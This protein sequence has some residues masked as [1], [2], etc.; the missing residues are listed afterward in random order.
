MSM[1]LDDLARELM[2]A[3]RAKRLAAH[4]K[5]WTPSMTPVTDLGYECIRRSV[6][7][8][9]WPAEARPIGEEL[10]SIFDEGKM[11]EKDVRNELLDLGHELVETEVNFRDP[12]LRVTGTID[13]K[14]EIP[15]ESSRKGFRRV[16]VEIKGLA[17]G[18]PKSF[19]QWK[20][21]GSKLL[22]RY[23]TQLQTYMFLTSETDGLGLFKNKMT[24]LW[25]IIP[26][27]LD[28]DHMT[29]V[30]KRAEGIRDA[31]AL[32]NEQKTEDKR[33]S[34]LPDRIADRSECETC[35]WFDSMCRPAEADVDPLLLV[36]D[37]ELLSQIEERENL[38]EKRRRFKVLDDLIKERFKF[39]KGD[40]FIV[41]DETG[42]A[43]TKKKHGRGI[44]VDIKRVGPR[45]I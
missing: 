16:P 19:E 37:E 45:A 6:Y 14:I 29:V 32:V 30:V 8:Q 20:N 31:V 36:G 44:R 3:Q 18:G 39:T 43:V 41:G 26:V 13:G 28:F 42:F 7:H 40:R 12:D 22:R 10:A 27:G 5:V 15:D 9:I 2:D 21:S 11:H 4:Q 1:S 23:Y 38:D 34:V 33:L 35:P 17:G 25:D 24:G